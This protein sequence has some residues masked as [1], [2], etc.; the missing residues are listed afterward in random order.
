[1][2]A[3]GDGWRRSTTVIEDGSLI[4]IGQ[5]NDQL[6]VKIKANKGLKMG[7]LWAKYDHGQLWPKKGSSMGLKYDR[8]QLGAE[9]GL[10]FK[11]YHKG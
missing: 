10:Y 9:I 7:Q 4:T 8:S 1:M 5:K 11:Q 6:W 3:N 2:A